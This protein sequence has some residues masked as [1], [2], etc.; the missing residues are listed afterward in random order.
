MKQTEFSAMW[1]K[2]VDE[3]YG[4]GSKQLEGVTPDEFAAAISRDDEQ[5]LPT[6]RCMQAHEQ[7]DTE[8]HQRMIIRGVACDVYWQFDEED[9]EAAGDDEGNLDWSLESVARIV[10]A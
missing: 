8:Y 2:L 7:G 4:S 3:Q 5:A 6:S 1:D 9:M 10:Y